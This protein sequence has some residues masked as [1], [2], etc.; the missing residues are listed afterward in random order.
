[1]DWRLGLLVLY[2]L[3]NCYAAHRDLKFIKEDMNCRLD[4]CSTYCA[5]TKPA[6]RDYLNLSISPRAHVCNASKVK[7]NFFFTEMFTDYESNKGIVDNETGTVYIIQFC[8]CIHNMQTYLT[9]E[10]SPSLG[11]ALAWAEESRMEW[12]TDTN[13]NIN[14]WDLSGECYERWY[15]KLSSS[16]IG[17]SPNSKGLYAINN[18]GCSLSWSNNSFNSDVHEYVHLYYRRSKF[19]RRDLAMVNYLDTFPQYAN[20]FACVKHCSSNKFQYAFVSL[21]S[22]H[23]STSEKI[24]ALPMVTG[25]EDLFNI[26]SDFPTMRCGSNTT[27]SVYKFVDSKNFGFRFWQC[28]NLQSSKVYEQIYED[29]KE[30]TIYQEGLEST[31]LCLEICG[32]VFGKKVSPSWL[33]SSLIIVLKHLNVDVYT[34]NSSRQDERISPD[35]ASRVYVWIH[36]VL[37]PLIPRIRETGVKS[38]FEGMGRNLNEAYWTCGEGGKF[39]TKEP[40]RTNCFDP[41]IN[42]YLDQIFPTDLDAVEMTQEIKEKLESSPMFG[43]TLLKTPKLLNTI[44]DKQII[45]KWNRSLEENRG[46]TKNILEMMDN[47]F[48]HQDLAWE[49]FHNKTEHHL[50]TFKLLG[51]VEEIGISLLDYVTKTNKDCRFSERNPCSVSI[52]RGG[53]LRFFIPWSAFENQTSREECLITVGSIKKLKKNDI[54]DPSEEENVELGNTILSFM[55]MAS[56]PING[57]VRLTFDNTNLNRL[58]GCIYWDTITNKWSNDGCSIINVHGPQVTCICNHLT[59]FSVL[60][61]SKNPND[62]FKQ[63]LTL[64][65]GSISTVALIFTQIFLHVNFSKQRGRA[66]KFSVELNHLHHK[67]SRL[68][69]KVIALWSQYIWTAAFTWF[70]LEGRLLYRVLIVVI[71]AHQSNIYLLYAIGYGFPLLVVTF[72][73]IAGVHFQ[74]DDNFVQ[75]DVCWLEGKYILGFMVPLAIVLA[76]NTYVLI[77]GTIVTYD[78]CRKQ[79]DVTFGQQFS[80]LARS[81]LTLS[82][83]LGVPWILGF[84]SQLHEALSSFSSFV[85]L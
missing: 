21:N 44:L 14:V 61:G 16:P 9:D 36:I 33:S 26:C 47:I 38:C 62:P 78:Y 73:I 57:P 54:I 5:Y 75:Q 81:G 11:S 8:E 30:L 41:W 34:S 84:F 68:T 18:Q 24:S 82:Y 40:D 13:T 55:V 15:Y 35:F 64:T 53:M 43:G 31:T 52:L 10:K 79:K 29:A 17:Y 71:N 70:G 66:S 27:D 4:D 76:W 83:I 74:D 51:Y 22:C 46:F 19:V 28:L 20:S 72:T 58:E 50:F 85:A 67:V 6:S 56:H 39:I 60:F 80:S 7:R 25:I 45:Q 1:M 42:D 3:D 49:E 65:L 32:E 12:R 77:K 23:C 48:H 59:S 63:G 69:C 37:A 2:L